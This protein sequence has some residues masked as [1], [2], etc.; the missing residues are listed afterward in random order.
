MG[1]GAAVGAGVGVATGVG[2]GVATG[3]GFGVATGVG[4]GVAFG[5]AAG[6][7]VTTVGVI[8]GVVFSGFVS[9]EGRLTV[10]SPSPA[11]FAAL[12]AA[13]S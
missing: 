9:P 10:P 12:A 11:A 13:A 3:V 7:G 5:V 6:V 8:F 2:V 4:V 1:V